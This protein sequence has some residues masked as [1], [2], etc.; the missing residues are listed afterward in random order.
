M[1]RGVCAVH[2]GALDHIVERLKIKKNNQDTLEDEIGTLF[3]GDE[4]VS[5]N[6]W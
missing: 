2:D 5:M 6:F 1:N 3:T 4:V